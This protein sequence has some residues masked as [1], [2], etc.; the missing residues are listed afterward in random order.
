MHLIVELFLITT[1]PAIETAPESFALSLTS[2]EELIAVEI[3][4]VNEAL[5]EIFALLRDILPEIEA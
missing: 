4:P 5:P 2:R 3:F 1:L